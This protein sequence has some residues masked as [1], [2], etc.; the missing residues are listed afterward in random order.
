MKKK[1]C[2][3]LAIYLILIVLFCLIPG[4]KI[5]AAN[6]K[7][8]YAQRVM[9]LQKKFPSGRYWNHVGSGRNNPDGYTKR[10]C[11]HHGNC[12]RGGR[13]YSGSC[14]CNSFNGVAI[15]CMGFAEKL[16]YDLFGTNP[17]TQWTKSYNLGKVKAGDIL[18]Y[19]YHSIFVTNV[20]GDILTYADCNSD[21]H[22]VIRWGAQISKSQIRGFSYIQHANN[23]NKVMKNK[24]KKIS[25]CK[26][27]GLKSSYSYTGKKIT[28][29]FTIKSGKTVLRKGKDYTIKW[30]NN[31]NAGKAVIKITGK[32][33]YIGTVKKV[34][35]IV[36]KK[37]GLRSFSQSENHLKVD[38]K[39]DKQATGYEILLSANGNFK[40]GNQKFNIGRNKIITKEIP[41]PVSQMGKKYYVKIRAYKVVD[42]K[43]RYGAYSKIKQVNYVPYEIGGNKK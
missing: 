37:V 19:G 39:R 8:T 31:V 38:W 7:G 3:R 23:Y 21:G 18:R 29:Q 43:R 2:R 20:S 16:G 36:P 15:Q 12:S 17:R 6:T 30:Q 33:N 13:D 4:K 26:I 10:P 9:Q 5:E 34:F 28:P 11:T 14:G 27:V 32:G 41:V 42:D 35:Y 25:S 24:Q 1:T 22:C 40:T